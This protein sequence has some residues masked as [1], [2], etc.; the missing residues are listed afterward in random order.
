MAACVRLKGPCG[1]EL[2]LD[3]GEYFPDDPGR[4]CPA[5]V[6]YQGARYTGSLTAVCAT[7]SAIGSRDDC[8]LHPDAL[9]WLCSLEDAAWEYIEGAELA[10]ILAALRAQGVRV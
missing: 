9:A 3:R 1:V 8:Q 4:G 10:P 7:G 6:E 2:V 5:L